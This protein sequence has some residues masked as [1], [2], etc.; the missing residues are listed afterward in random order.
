[1]QP[2]QD[3]TVEDRVSRTQYQYSLEDPDAG[4]AEHSGCRKLIAKL[5]TLP[6]LRDVASDQQ[7]DGSQV[8]LVI[9][10]DTA[11]RL[12]ITPADDRRHALRRV[13]AAAGLDHVHAVEPVSRGARGRS[14]V[15]AAARRALQNIYISLRQRQA[16][17][18]SALSSTSR[19]ATVPLVV[20][21][22]GQFPA[23]TISFNLAPGYSLGDAV[24]AIDAAQRR[25]RTCR[26]ASRPR[27]RVPRRPFRRR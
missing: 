2:V 24:T 13:R 4:R 10:R 21:H 8:E 23:V 20:S 11:S 6:E 26:P 5:G 1:M 15:S 27:S 22:Q 17:C 14:R 18:R 9:D 19:P 12:G 25:D 7:N 16:R 3:L